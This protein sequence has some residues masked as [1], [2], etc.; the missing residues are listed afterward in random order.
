MDICTCI[1]VSLCCIP[2][3]NTTIIQFKKKKKEWAKVISLSQARLDQ[4][5]ACIPGAKTSF[6]LPAFSAAYDSGWT[7]QPFLFLQDLV[8]KTWKPFITQLLSKRTGKYFQSHT[9]P[10]VEHNPKSLEGKSR[11]RVPV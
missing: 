5:P 1:T 3:I 4:I 9:A 8:L 2:E 7:S 10:S 6:F 11:S